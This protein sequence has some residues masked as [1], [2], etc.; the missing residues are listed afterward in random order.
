MGHAMN[1]IKQ[2]IV[3]RKD[4]NLRKTELASQVATASMGFLL[5]NNESERNDVINV[6]LSREEAIWL[7]GS[8]EK[9]IVAVE[10]EQDLRDLMFKAE[11]EGIGVY[12]VHGKIS[13]KFDDLTIMCA[14]LGPDES[15]VINHVTGHLKSI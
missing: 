4:L 9:S 12:P 1:D 11:M 7:N 14:A 5:D 3:V 10:S 6:K 2:V 8:F 15:S 13:S